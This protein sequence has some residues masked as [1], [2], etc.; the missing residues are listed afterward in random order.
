MYRA[1]RLDLNHVIGLKQRL[2]DREVRSRRNVSLLL[3]W[4]VHLAR[5]V[6]LGATIFVATAG[7]VSP[8]FDTHVLL[9]ALVALEGDYLT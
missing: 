8:R 6:A 9:L 1:T 5:A 2:K 7:P 3:G 4:H